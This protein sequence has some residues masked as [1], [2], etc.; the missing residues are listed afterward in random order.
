MFFSY[1][2]ES[3]VDESTRTDD[4][5]TDTASESDRE[6][7]S[8]TPVSEAGKSTHHRSS[9]HQTPPHHSSLGKTRSL[10]GNQR[11]HVSVGAQGRVHHEMVPGFGK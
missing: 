10:G 11:Y 5:E 1:D 9:F 7:S 2:G 8:F 6:G 3:D 4:E